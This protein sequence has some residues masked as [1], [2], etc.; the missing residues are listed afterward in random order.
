MTAV[1]EETA[2]QLSLMGVEGR[3][4]DNLDYRSSLSSLSS[5]TVSRFG[6]DNI[7]RLPLYSTSLG[8]PSPL[9]Q[10]FLV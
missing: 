5:T 10:R 2:D 6:D 3:V 1:M 4:T 8:L 9:P 7:V